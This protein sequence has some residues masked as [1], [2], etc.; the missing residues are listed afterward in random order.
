MAKKKAKIKSIKVKVSERAKKVAKSLKLTKDREIAYDFA[1][2]VYQKIGKLVKSIVLF[3]S[4]A[5]GISA[6]RSDIDIVIL[7]DD[8]TVQWD[9]ELIA[10]YRG[11]LG[12]IIREN[13]YI[14]PLHINTVRITTWWS[15]MMRG[16]PVVINIIRWGEPLIDFGGFFAPLKS[17]LA[18]GKIRATPEMIYITLGRSPAHLVRCKASMINAF[19]AI[20]WAFIDASHAAL[21]SAKVSPPSPEHIP[22]MMRDHLVEKGFLKR[23]YVDWY[24]EIYSLMHKILHGEVSDV[25]GEEIQ[26][27]RERADEYLRQMALAVKKITGRI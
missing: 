1:H 3:G 6:P 2:K 4:A 11:E 17:L 27:W 16:E 24:R 14:K 19:E 15:E 9:D 12:K 8:A 22:A 18:Q 7:I 26:M 21:I 10:W 13:P 23:R 25:N 20:Y 5:K